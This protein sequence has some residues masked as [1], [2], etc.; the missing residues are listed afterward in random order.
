MPEG[1][2][3]QVMTA[4]LCGFGIMIWLF[5]LR[6]KYQKQA[7][8]HVYVEFIREEGTSYKKLLEQKEGYVTLPGNKKKGVPEK[9][10]AVSSD[11]TYKGVYPEGW[12]PKFLQTPVEKML[13]REDTWEPVY[14]RGDPLKSPALIRNLRREKFTQIGTEQAQEEAM[15]LKADKAKLKPSLVYLLSFLTLGAIGAVGIL[16][17]IQMTGMANIVEKISQGLG[18][19]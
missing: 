8:N 13:F 11:A 5:M 19:Q 10:Y 4:M 16:L 7:M 18:I 2:V 9:D 6:F 17:Y 14:N 3:I 15:Q 1:W 12:C